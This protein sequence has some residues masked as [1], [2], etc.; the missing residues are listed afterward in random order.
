[1]CVILL[2]LG[3]IRVCL[4]LRIYSFFRYG[5]RTLVSSLLRPFDTFLLGCSPG[6][7]ITDETRPS[8][9][10]RSHVRHSELT[11]HQDILWYWSDTKSIL[12]TSN[13]STIVQVS[14]IST[15]WRVDPTTNSKFFF[16][17]FFPERGLVMCQI[18]GRYLSPPTKFLTSP[19][20][21]SVKP[22]YLLSVARVHPSNNVFYFVFLGSVTLTTI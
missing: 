4:Y 14:Y 7:S 9:A 1:M 6:T 21:K 22:S 5:R 15:I 16:F 19:N 13:L 10:S 3:A 11:D 2:I 18:K 17:F 12:M 20:V 8:S